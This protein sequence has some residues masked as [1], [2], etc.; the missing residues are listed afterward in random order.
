MAT[1]SNSKKVIYQDPR[2]ITALFNDTRLAWIWLVVRLYLGYE[3]I[4]SGLEKLPNPAWMSGQALKGF[5]ERAILI[6]DAPA[7]PAIAFGWYRSFLTFLLNTGSYSWFA[8]L[9]AIGE[10]LV[11]VA[12][13]V[14]IFV[15]FAAFMGGFLNWNFIMAGTASVNGVFIILAILLLIAWKTAGYWGL[16]RWALPL[17]GTPGAPGKL[18]A[19]KQKL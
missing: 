19:K 16:D 13:V 18:F 4:T 3:W 8:K 1:L 2:W 12:L 15:G 11:G 7:R 5:W 17:V 9:V 10:V 14:G 6:P